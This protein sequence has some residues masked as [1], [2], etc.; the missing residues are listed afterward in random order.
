MDNIITKLVFLVF[1]LGIKSGTSDAADCGNFTDCSSCS[2]ES[3]CGWCDTTLEC[4]LGDEWGSNSSYCLSWFYYGCF[5][6]G[7]TAGC[8]DQIEVLDCDETH[9]NEELSSYNADVCQHCRGVESCFQHD[10]GVPCHGWNET[11]CP[12]GLPAHDESTPHKNV[13]QIRDNVKAIDPAV[14]TLYMCPVSLEE[15]YGDS[16]ALFLA[17]YPTSF[18]DG[19]VIVSGQAGGVMHIVESTAP[20]GPYAFV[21]GSAANIEDVVAYS[22]F[23]EEVDPVAIDDETTEE[24][25]PD[26]VLLSD[27]LNGDLPTNSSNVTVINSDIPVYK[28]VGNAYISGTEDEWVSSFLVFDA[29]DIEDLSLNDGDILA[30]SQSNGWLETVTGVNAALGDEFSF[31][32]TELVRCGEELPDTNTFAIPTKSEQYI[33]DLHCVGGDNSKG[34]LVYENKTLESLA[35]SSGD[36]IVGR[37]SGSFLS[38]VVSWTQNGGFVF[39]EVAPVSSLQEDTTDSAISTRRRRA[40]IDASVTFSKT[41][42]VSL[43]VSLGPAEVSFGASAGYR[44]GF[45][46]SMELGWS[47]PF[48]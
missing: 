30:G 39:V 38:K 47:S 1:L 22:S 42:S 13:V 23:K 27:A 31:V 35:F 14:T 11:V 34:I 32:Q 45:E 3:E 44:L 28:C 9:C 20:V 2:Q 36:T 25:V 29:T 17:P 37:K 21:L 41:V 33:P 24:D 46:F 48:V 12:D 6:A 40:T 10:G 15:D 7:E 18:Q 26:A 43:T 16:A 19:D 4:L 5:S 8:S